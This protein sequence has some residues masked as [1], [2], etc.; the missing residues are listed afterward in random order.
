MNTIE[1]IKRL[2]EESGKTDYAIKKETGLGN[3]ILSDLKAG[4]AENPSAK[5]VKILSKYFN[6]SSD[7]L[8]CLTDTPTPLVNEVQ[9]KKAVPMERPKYGIALSN[10]KENC[11]NLASDEKFVNITHLYSNLATMAIRSA[12]YGELVKWLENRGVDVAGILGL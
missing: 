8:L 4:R 6:I 7:Y 12:L 2:I 3:S 5:T 9:T 10:Y 11:E 1:R